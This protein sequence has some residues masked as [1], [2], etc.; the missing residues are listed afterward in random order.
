M[1]KSWDDY[2]GSSD[3][4]DLENKGFN[5]SIAVVILLRFCLI[6]SIILLFSCSMH[7]NLFVFSVE[8]SD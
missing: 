7:C 8:I 5:A 3:N 6:T 1:M 2:I 4:Q